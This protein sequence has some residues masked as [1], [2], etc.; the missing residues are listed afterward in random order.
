MQFY[1]HFIFFPTMTSI[2]IFK[3]QPMCYTDGTRLRAKFR[4]R[5]TRR[6]RGDSKQ[7]IE[8]TF[9]C[10]IIRNI[11]TAHCVFRLSELS[12]VRNYHRINY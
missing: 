12:I 2:D 7:T 9:K 6:F 10:S 1:K 4:R 5:T 3:T 8:A 11:G